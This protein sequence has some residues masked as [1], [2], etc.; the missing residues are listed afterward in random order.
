MVDRKAI[1]FIPARGGSKR[2]VNKNISQL[3]DKNLLQI[4]I[5]L[6]E[7]AKCFERIVVS[8]DSELILEASLG[9]GSKVSVVKRS[10]SS[11][12][13]K[14][15]TEEAILE[16]ILASEDNHQGVEIICLLQL[17]S[18]F[19]CKEHL[20]KGYSLIRSGI[21]SS[22]IGGVEMHPFIWR[23]SCDLDS[24]SEPS[25]DPVKRPRTQEIRKVF[26]E[27]GAF[28]FFNKSDFISTKNRITSPVGKVVMDIIHGGIDIN[29]VHDLELARKVAPALLEK[30]S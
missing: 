9:Y 23:T 19:T 18:P 22:V 1:C 28:Y 15:S 13:D 4:G 14:S 20:E 6:A 10:S 2:I 8:S 17:T 5:E 25:Y 24:L 11:S 29:D 7:S 21:Y 16:W 27:T 26:I 12:S 3:G 30:K